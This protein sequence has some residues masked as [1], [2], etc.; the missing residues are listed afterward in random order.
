MYPIFHYIA[1]VFDD[2]YKLASLDSIEQFLIIN[3]HL[4]SVPSEKEVLANGINIGEIQ[5]IQLQKIEELTLY[6]VEINKEIKAL[7]LENANLKK[8]LLK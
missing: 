7:K 5:A 2:N 3:N 4:P 1:F 8:Y 6:L